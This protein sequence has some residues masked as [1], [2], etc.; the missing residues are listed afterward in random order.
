MRFG[1][2]RRRFLEQQPSQQQY[3]KPAR[4][5][6]I[7]LGLLLA[8]ANMAI[9]FLA[10]L[11]IPFDWLGPYLTLWGS[12]GPLLLYLQFPLL[13]FLIFY[14]LGCRHVYA[15]SHANAAI[16]GSITAW[17]ASSLATFA[18]ILQKASGKA[19]GIHPGAEPL[20]PRVR[21]HW[22]T[23][24]TASHERLTLGRKLASM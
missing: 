20:F 18:L 19:P 24:R 3:A 14:L 6:P 8:V 7:R 1:S 23:F 9:L 17:L 2:S 15:T 10:H 5:H 22:E 12:A 13:F 4:Q 21:E 16:R 11:L